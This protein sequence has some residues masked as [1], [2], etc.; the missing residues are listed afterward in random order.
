MAIVDERP[1][2]SVAGA[3]LQPSDELEALLRGAFARAAARPDAVQRFAALV[4]GIETKPV[5]E[6][7]VIIE[8]IR[9]FM[10][11]S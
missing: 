10:A 7:Q 4:D 5:A 1:V 11:A 3:Y 8:R 6:Q 9:A 2:G